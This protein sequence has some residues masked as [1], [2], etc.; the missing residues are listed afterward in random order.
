MADVI[1][2]FIAVV[3]FASTNIDDLLV[4]MLFFGNPDFSTRQVVTGQYIGITALIALSM[5]AFFFKLIVP[6]T[7]MGL[8]GIL[9]IIIGLKN[10]KELK[11]NSI[12][13]F[14]F[15]SNLDENIAEL[16]GN[17]NKFLRF[18]DSKTFSVAAT[19]FANGGDN[20]AVYIPLFAMADLYQMS[21]TISVFMVMIGFWCFMSLRLVK[22]KILGDKIQKYGHIIFPVVLILLGISILAR[23]LF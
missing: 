23:N 20:I 7:W 22:N 4:L 15:N 9:P 8:L 17:K 2:I 18:I 13:E 14:K 16:N 1:L 21:L 11:S 12:K 3:A 6:T 19:S 10:L 5:L